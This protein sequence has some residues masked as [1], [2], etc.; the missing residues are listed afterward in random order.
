MSIRELRLSGKKKKEFQE[1]VK[2]SNTLNE[3][4]S[5]QLVLRETKKDGSQIIEL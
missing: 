5:Y 4:K 2:G 3:S 1:K